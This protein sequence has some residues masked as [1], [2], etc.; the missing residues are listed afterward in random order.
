M[1]EPG[2]YT[3]WKDK[4]C[5]DCDVSE[6]AMEHKKRKTLISFGGIWEDTVWKNRIWIFNG[7]TERKLF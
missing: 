6:N 5:K 2:A 3:Q 7:F 1:K 4:M